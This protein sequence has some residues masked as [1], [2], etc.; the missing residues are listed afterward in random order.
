MRIVLFIKELCDKWLTMYVN[1]IPWGDAKRIPQLRYQG[2]HFCVGWSE[3]LLTVPS[4][5]ADFVSPNWMRSQ[6]LTDRRFHWCKAL[7]NMFNK[8]LMTKW[9]VHSKTPTHSLFISFEKI[10]MLVFLSIN[11]KDN[12][13]NPCGKGWVTCLTQGEFYVTIYTFWEVNSF[14]LWKGWNCWHKNYKTFSK[15]QV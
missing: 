8:A 2:K 15:L 3:I 5:S 13:D 14:F 11:N 12:R 10:V 6:I 1:L 4:G 7:V 9:H